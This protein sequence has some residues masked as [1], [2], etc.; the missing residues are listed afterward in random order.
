LDTELIS[1]AKQVE[2]SRRS[3]LKKAAIFTGGAII[4]QS[5]LFAS[6]E[7]EKA[8]KLR[9]IHQ[10]KDYYAEFYEKDS[11]KISGLFEINKAFMDTRAREITRIDI[12]LINLLYEINLRVGIEKKFNIVSG[13]RTPQTNDWLRHQLGGQNVA[14]NSYHMKG[15]AADIFVADV[16]LHKLRDIARSLKRGGVGYYP[17]K[18]FIHVDVGPE[19]YWRRG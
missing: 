13:Y 11:Y 12:E 3:F 18:G 8:L 4:S 2:D 1:D 5:E 7:A 14:K 17:K 15:Q 6:S 10:G 19:R 16:P 9:A